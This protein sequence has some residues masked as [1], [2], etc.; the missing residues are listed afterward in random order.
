MG[1]AMGMGMATQSVNGEWLI[2][3]LPLATIRSLINPQSIRF[4]R[5]NMN[6]T[7]R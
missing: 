1:M 7:N 5:Q 3:I 6:N 4:A 2:E